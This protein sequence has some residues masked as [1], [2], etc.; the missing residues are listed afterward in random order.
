MS[1]AHAF[2]PRVLGIVEQL[3]SRLGAVAGALEAR[4]RTL[5]HADLH[6][7]NVIFDAR[8]DGR[9]VTLLDWQTVSLGSPAWDVTMFLSSSLSVE[10]R[11]AAEREVLDRYLTLLFMHGVRGYSVE[12]LG[13]EHR[14]ALLV[15]VA[16]TVGGVAMFGPDDATSRERALQEDALAADG[17]L[18]AALSD[19]NAEGLL[20]AL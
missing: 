8:G 2:R 3:R 12:D 10:D 14:L 18:V 6:L 11:R 16:G 20:R 13:L 19:H 1:G 5:I 9:S 4:S 15:L 17:R 7:D